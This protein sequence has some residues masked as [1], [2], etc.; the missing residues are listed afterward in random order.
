MKQISLLEVVMRNV[1]WV[2]AISGG[3]ALLG[4]LTW[5]MLDVSHMQKGFTLPY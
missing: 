3:V 2:A 4:W 5:V 1:A